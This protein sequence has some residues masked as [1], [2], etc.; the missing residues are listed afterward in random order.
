MKTIFITGAANG[1]GLATAKHFAGLGWFVG[2]YDINSDGL[3]SL[4]D[5]GEFP[6]ACGKH[7]DVTQ[8]N[9]IKEALA[10]FGSHTNGRLD[11]LVNN[12]GVLSSGAFEDIKPEAHD[13]I[14]DINV[15]GLTTVAQEGFPL[16]KQTPGSTLVNLCSASS[17]HSL[18]LLAVYSASKFYVNGLTE[19]LNI[20][21]AQH[22]IRVTA[23]K[24]P[25]VNTSMGHA[26]DQRIT[27]RMAVDVEPEQIAE[28]IEMAIKG[29][30]VSYLLGA[31]AKL[32]GVIDKL[33][34]ESGRRRLVRY[35][36][37]H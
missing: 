13:L 23:V 14:I 20:E 4:L 28:A 24:P 5:S 7:C 19:A 33:L 10:H 21:W 3:Q 26:I 9:S 15:K 18:P 8:R 1:I 25:I 29:K 17:V 11:V 31:S 37:N 12:A 27:Q 32:W 34:P 6:H 2:L 30:R 16:L 35:L 22:D 36:S